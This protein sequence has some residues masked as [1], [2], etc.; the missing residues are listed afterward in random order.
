MHARIPSYRLHRPSGRAVV[1]LSGKDHYLGRHG[2]PESRAAYE[3]L[4]A[5]WLATRRRPPT[6]Q[7]AACDL[8]VNELLLAYWDHARSYYVKEGAPTSEPGTIRQALRPVRELYGGTRAV[9]FGP[10]ALKA[11]R[12]RMIELGWCR[13]YINKQIN[14]VKRVFSWAV[15]EELIPI[16]V[17]QALKTVPG[18][19]M[20]RTE[21][22]E[23]P[24]V[25]SVHDGLVERTLPHL[26]P[27]VSTMVRVQRLTGMRP[28]EV[29]LMRGADIDR[30]DPECWV[31][32]PT[33]HKGE[34]QGRERVIYL[35][36]RAQSLLEPYLG[37]EPSGYLF[38]PRRAEELRRAT[39]RAGRQSP[40]TPSQ[41]ARRPKLAPR[42]SPGDVYD[43]AS[44]RKAIR[45]V[46]Q[47]L[48]LPIWFPHQLRHTAASEIRSRHGLEA[49]QA[50]LGHRELGTTQIY[51]EVDQL[52][53]RRVMFEIG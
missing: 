37:A 27:T 28:Q 25:G 36:P 22:R 9:E 11:V 29:E 5:E 33:R 4:V 43:A 26:S 14:R 51:A 48:G 40:V 10:L 47:R 34:H 35:G 23:K 45:R 46:C 39:L 12:Q 19:R 50:V 6:L 7:T 3:R 32:R 42:R 20:G 31:Y 41:K 30:T 8:T 49:S 44:Y 53:A 17:D 2:S 21:A 24:P 15:G 38:S 1:T 18:L 16:S 52:T 13:T